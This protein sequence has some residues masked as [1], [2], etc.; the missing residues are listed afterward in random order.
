MTKSSDPPQPASRPWPRSLSSFVREDLWPQVVRSDIE[1]SEDDDHVYVSAAVPGLAEEDIN[2]SLNQGALTISGEAQEEE[3]PKGKKYYRTMQRSYSYQVALPSSVEESGER[4]TL[5]NG[6]LRIVFR[7][8]PE[9]KP[10]HIPIRGKA[11]S[12]A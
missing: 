4:A 5:Q 8:S 1:L 3:R 6:L 9:A 2:I 11:S 12:H 7:K 10:R